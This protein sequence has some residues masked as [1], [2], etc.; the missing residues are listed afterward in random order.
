[1]SD[2]LISVQIYVLYYIVLFV[3][4]REKLTHIYVKHER[5]ETHDGCSTEGTEHVNTDDTE[6]YN[7]Q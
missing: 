5:G 3:Y 1:M 4:N 6:S 2:A 7:L